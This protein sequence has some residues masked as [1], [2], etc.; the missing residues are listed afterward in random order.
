[1]CLGVGVSPPSSG[2]LFGI[3]FERLPCSLLLMVL[4]SAMVYSED[5]V[6][7][8]KLKMRVH[9]CLSGANACCRWEVLLVKLFFETAT[10]AIS[11]WALVSR[12]SKDVICNSGLEGL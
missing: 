3:G 4:A 6:A 2:V 12:L 5:S 9:N 8:M 7:E 1:M 10:L 11:A